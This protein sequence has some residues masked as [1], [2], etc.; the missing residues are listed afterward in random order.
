M[1]RTEDFKYIWTSDGFPELYNLQEDPTETR[2]LINIERDRADK[3]AVLMEDRLG[4]FEAPE[5]TETGLDLDE[6]TVK[7][8]EQLG[9]LA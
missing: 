4:Q 8:L 1:A 9:Y 6:D 2:N 7:K 3:M 5:R